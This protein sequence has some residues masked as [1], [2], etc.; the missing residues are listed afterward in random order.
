MQFTTHATRRLTPGLSTPQNPRN[1]PAFGPWGMLV[2]L[3]LTMKAADSR[4]PMDACST[5]GQSG[6]TSGK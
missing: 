5:C 3:G 2:A 6:P 1:P 4:G